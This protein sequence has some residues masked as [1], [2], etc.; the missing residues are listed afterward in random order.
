MKT[1]NFKST[2][3]KQSDFVI[4]LPKNYKKIKLSFFNKWVD[5]LEGGDFRQCSGILCEPNNKKLTY[6]CL[7]VL[8]KVQGRLVKTQDGFED[9]LHGGTGELNRKNPLFSILKS[10]G[11]FP[12]GVKVYNNDDG[13]SYTVSD[14][15][16]CNDDLKLS[17][18]DIAKIIKTLYKA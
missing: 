17:F 14:L 2:K 12:T 10:R 13:D 7:G 18:K 5:A 11:E 16:E 6:C 8:S 3:G 9:T 4:S 15:V 1:I